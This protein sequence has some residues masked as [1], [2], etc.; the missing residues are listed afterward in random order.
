MRWQCWL[1]VFVGWTRGVR[2]GVAGCGRF[3]E[4][5]ATRQSD[6][7]QEPPTPQRTFEFEHA[8][9]AR[10]R[11]GGRQVVEQTYNAA[12]DGRS[13]SLP[14]RVKIAGQEYR[15][16]RQTPRDVATLFGKIRLRRC[17]YQ[18]SEPGQPGIAPLEHR[19]GIVAGAATPALADEAA[20]W[21]ADLPQ[22][23][24]RTILKQR[25]GV[26]WADATLRKVVA[27]VAERYEPHRA[28][29][30][31]ARLLEL[32]KT[33]EKTSGKHAPTLCVGR[34]GVMVPMRPFWHEAACATVSVLARNGERLGTVYLG[35][36][37]EPGQGTLTAELTSLLEQVLR[38][39]RGQLPRL[40]YVTDAGTHPQDYYRY[41][42][43]WMKHPRTGEKLPW[44]WNVD[45]YHACER[46]SVLA[47][48]LFGSGPEAEAWASKQRHV[49]KEKP[50]GASR[51]VQRAKALRRHRG[52]R[53]SAKAFRG[54]CDYLKKY[55]PH[56]NYAAC[57]RRKL[58]IGSGVTEAACKTIFGARFKQSG[59]RWG[60]EHS[61]RILH[62]RL[63][64][65]SQL[66]DTVRITALAAY[67]PPDTLNPTPNP[68]STPQKRLTCLL[69]A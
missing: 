29:A 9:A 49:L 52:L 34:D 12:E 51:V 53:C 58:P 14:A 41:R 57:Q 26:A 28:A 50:Q 31:E 13:E 30:G 61:Q 59:M 18:S 48:A 25:H 67:T 40:H 35:Q 64:H 45:F 24:T 5:C 22:Q 33:A 69:P 47:E 11:E 17:I 16:N 10:L 37:P 68:R 3:A 6:F 2:S 23:Q 7:L 36:M 43:A 20:R 60:E 38:A 8:V 19:L 44:T 54:A 56:M 42:L 63:I 32:L 46:V 62:L 4:T 66:W 1:L 65:K 55:A 15:R 21:Q 27:G 39:W